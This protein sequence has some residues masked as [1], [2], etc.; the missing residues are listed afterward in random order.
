MRILRLLATGTALLIVGGCADGHTILDPT[1]PALSVQGHSSGLPAARAR[2]IQTSGHF[3]AIVDFST[4]T[5]TPRGRNCLLQV[6]GQLVFS[7]TIEGAATG[8]TTALV[9]ASCS[10]VAASPPGT[11]RDVF[12]SELT[13]EGTV[14]GAPARANVLY[15]GRV[16]PG[17]QIAGRLVLSNG[18]QGRLEV[19]AQVAVG[20]EYAGSVVVR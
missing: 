10:D 7:G 18:V 16:Q 11:F 3:D 9:F 4:L 20:G 6:N 5:L 17:G 15:M 2:R 8:Q 12:R 14:D 19:E 13:F 1:P